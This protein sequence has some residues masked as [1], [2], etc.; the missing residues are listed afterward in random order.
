MLLKDDDAT[1]SA[2][3]FGTWHSVAL[4]YN[5]GYFFLPKGI[6]LPP[7]YFQCLARSQISS[8]IICL[9][10]S[11]YFHCLTSNFAILPTVL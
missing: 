9:L 3:A 8:N 10:P 4:S 7:C 1:C 11:S 5:Y 2:T 6:S